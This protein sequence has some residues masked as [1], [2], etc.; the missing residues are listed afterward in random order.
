MY[1][2]TKWTTGEKS[3]KGI[4]GQLCFDYCFAADTGDL[5]KIEGTLNAQ[6]Q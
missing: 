4:C 5:L 1:I 2:K 6:G 3:L